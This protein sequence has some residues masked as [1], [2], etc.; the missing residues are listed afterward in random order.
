MVKATMS[1]MN[2]NTSYKTKLNQINKKKITQKLLL[3]KQKLN[4]LNQIYKYYLLTI[5][6]LSHTQQV[7]NGN[8]GV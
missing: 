6:C 1:A 5:K 8:G 3:H 4:N 2:W 7:A